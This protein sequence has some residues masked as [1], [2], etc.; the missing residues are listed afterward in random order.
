M[1]ECYIARTRAVA[2]RQLG[3]EMIIMS[4]TDSTLFNL[5]AVAAVIWQAADGITPLATIVARDVCSSFDVEPDLALRD[6]E[7]FATELASHG[8]LLLA[9]CPILDPSALRLS[10]Q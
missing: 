3:E 5:N 6:A 1:K 7:E 2:A 4:A 10:S 9:D 8:I